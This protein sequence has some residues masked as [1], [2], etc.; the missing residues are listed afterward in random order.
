MIFYYKYLFFSCF[1]TISFASIQISGQVQDNDGS[2]LNNANVIIVNTSLGTQTNSEGN[3]IIN[4]NKNDNCELQVSHIGYQKYNNTFDCNEDQYF[5]IRLVNSPLDFDETV[6]VGTR[7]MAYLK[8]SPVLTHVI[9]K[10]EISESFTYNVN[11]ILKQAMPNI[12]VVPSNHTGDRLKMQ[13]LDNRYMLFLIDGDKMTGEYAGNIDLSIID[14]N[15]IEK[16]EIV[17][18]SLSTLYGSNAIG[19]V[20]NIISKKKKDKFWVNNVISK[21]DIMG[22]NKSLSIGGKNNSISYNI[23]YSNKNF[24]GYDLTPT[25]IDPFDYTLKAYDKKYYKYSMDYSYD[26]NSSLSLSFQKYNSFIIDYDDAIDNSTNMQVQIYSDLLKKYEDNIYKIKFDKIFSSNSSMKLTVMY[27]NYQKINY[28][29]Y[30]YNINQFDLNSNPEEFVAGELDHGNIYLQ[31]NEVLNNHNLVIGVEK[32]FDYYH[33]YNIYDNSGNVSSY[34][35]FEGIDQTKKYTETSLFMHDQ[36]YFSKNTEIYYGL[37]YT[38]AMNFKGKYIQAIS[39]MNRHPSGYNVRLNFSSGYRIPSLK[40]LY[41]EYPDHFIPLYGNPNLKPTL[42]KNY[43]LSFDKRTSVND[44]S[45]DFYIRDIENFIS[46][47]YNT[48]YN[49]AALIYRNYDYVL[50]NGFNI[51]YRRQ[52]NKNSSIKFVYNY[53]SLDSESN[54]ILEL[55]SNHSLYL[56]YK[57]L[58]SKNL[59]M[60]A[61]INYAGEKFNFNQEDD[62]VGSPS[63]TILDPY[64]ISNLIFSY[65]YQDKFNLKFGIKNIFDYKDSRADLGDD[66][67]NSYDP[68]KRLYFEINI[69]YRKE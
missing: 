37:R 66:L 36:F 15:N 60:L 29:P 28:Y 24:S 40:E 9:S 57:Y 62:F 44:F 30:Y 59:S 45:L 13:A 61:T 68:G 50:I 34:S 47:E 69:N 12:Q 1:I 22:A 58:F 16:I 42:S 25:T 21:D 10:E 17:E 27:E 11:D 4:L 48:E 67:L 63:V 51:N 14:V 8:D 46:T 52:I 56:K 18:N 64:W 2:L 53:V 35:I 23:N 55:I 54:E 3:F 5:S 7:R 39:I 43:S 33:S 41:Y 38:R 20:V 65:N 19:G 31:Y 32:V 49:N 26:S 6:V